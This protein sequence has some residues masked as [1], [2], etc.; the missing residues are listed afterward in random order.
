MA[1]VFTGS[2]VAVAFAVFVTVAVRFAVAVAVG[3][4]FGVRFAVTVGVGVAVAVAVA[5]FV[6][7]GVGVLVT[8]PPYSSEEPWLTEPSDP[9]V[10]GAEVGPVVMP[11]V[12]PVVIAVG[13]VVISVVTGTGT[14]P[15][16]TTVVAGTVVRVSVGVRVALPVGSGVPVAVTA[17]FC[18]TALS[19]M[20]APVVSWTLRTSTTIG[21]KPGPTTLN[22][23]VASA[24]SPFGRPFTVSAARIS[25]LCVRDQVGVGRVALEDLGGLELHDLDVPVEHEDDV[26]LLRGEVVVVV[27]RGRDRL[28]DL[29][30]GDRGD[31]ELDHAARARRGREGDD[32]E[33]QACQ[34]LYRYHRYAY[35]GDGLK[36]RGARR[37]GAAPSARREGGCR[38]FT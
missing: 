4:A 32:Q 21:V 25:R 9:P 33:E 15:V 29:R 6:T 14:E 30:V 26:S 3:V 5:V 24:P 22:F 36:E 19:V 28:P 35:A 23:T 10:T 12:I 18:E 34:M 1:V 7:V 16:G 27:D 8:T 11:V 13:G 37:P 20:S 31:V 17:P 38:A 2:D